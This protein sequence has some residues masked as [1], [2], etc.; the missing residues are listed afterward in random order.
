MKNTLPQVASLRTSRLTALLDT[1]WE[2]MERVLRPTS[3][4][5]T[6]EEGISCV[7]DVGEKREW[8]WEHGG[9]L[10][11]KTECM[12][13]SSV[14]QCQIMKAVMRI[15]DIK[16]EETVRERDLSN[17]MTRWRT[18]AVAMCIESSSP[19]ELVSL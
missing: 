7:W 3:T 2:I 15:A 13:S 5:I 11:N 4:I 19:C 12:I 14:M 6:P 8:K 16:P 17:V 9:G 1:R 10:P 18:V